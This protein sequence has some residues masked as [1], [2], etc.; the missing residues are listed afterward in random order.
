M[1][2]LYT[3]ITASASAPAM[4]LDSA[5]CCCGVSC[6]AWEIYTKKRH[7]IFLL[8]IYNTSRIYHNIS[9]PPLSNRSRIRGGR[10]PRVALAPGLAWL[11]QSE[12]APCLGCQVIY[13]YIYIFF[14]VCMCVYINKYL[15]IIYKC[16]YL[17]ML[18][19][20]YIY[21]LAPGLAWLLQ[22]EIAACLRRQ[23]SY[24][25][26]YI[27]YLYLFMYECKYK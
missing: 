27:M 2:Y 4:F 11:L 8:Y 15:L 16:L 20:K 19:Y 6:M 3:Y 18:I 23:V 21:I 5:L 12:I 25:Y 9:L 10:A 7:Q 22:S 26:I 14:Y 13:I 24:I 17:Y 1:R